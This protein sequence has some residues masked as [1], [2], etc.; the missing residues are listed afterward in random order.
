M[1]NRCGLCKYFILLKP[2]YVTTSVLQ[3]NGQNYSAETPAMFPEATK[4]FSRQ[5][6][7]KKE[8]DT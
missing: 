5:F 7:E 6:S 1:S 4:Y 2:H 3:V 8:N